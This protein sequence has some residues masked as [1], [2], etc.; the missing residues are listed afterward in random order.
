MPASA[1]MPAICR[2]P[3]CAWGNGGR[4]R[5]LTAEVLPTIVVDLAGEIVE[6]N[7]AA[8][9]RFPRLADLGMDHPLLRRA[10]QWLGRLNDEDAVREE[11]YANGQPFE[12]EMTYDE[13]ARR[14]RF[15]V[16]DA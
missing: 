8:A 11:V 1:A 14:F 7:D 15:L 13:A 10:P 16:R 2:M 4:S 3:C 9:Q 6:M 12:V 5:P